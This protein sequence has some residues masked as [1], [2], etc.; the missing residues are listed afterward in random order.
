ML[1]A[2]GAINVLPSTAWLE[3]DIRPLPGQTQEYIDQLLVDALGDMAAEVEI[4]HLITED[5]TQSPTSGPLY[6]AIV[7][8]YAEFFPDA[9][10]V[11]TLAA[12][13][14]DLRI[15]RRNGGVGYGF[16]LHRRG[17]T[18]GAVL[19]QLHSHDESV[20]IEDVILTAKAYR[21]LVRRFVG[22]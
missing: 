9:A 3:L 10:V 5:A 14:S 21:S 20:D 18:L 4:T 1:R 2:G 16:A 17:Q 13:G 7:E 12:G 11:P 22:A 8:T 6:E 15:A 19:D